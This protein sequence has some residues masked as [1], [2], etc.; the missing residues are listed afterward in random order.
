MQTFLPYPDFKETARVLDYRRLG[1][2]RVEAM[3]A[4][5]GLL[6]AELCGW[7]HHPLLKMWTGYEFAL[8]DYMECMIKEWVDRGYKNNI[9]PDIYLD[10]IPNSATTKYPIWLGDEDFHK[11][12]QS[13]LKRK[14]PEHYNMFGDIPD[15]LPYIWPVR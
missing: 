12:H 2:Q 4:L 7:R 1:K 13:N 6:R 5:N 15:N 14:L 8:L 10:L 3:Q 11:S 9:N